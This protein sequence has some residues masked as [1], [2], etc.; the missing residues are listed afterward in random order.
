MYAREG[1]ISKLILEDLYI[2]YGDWQWL[3][4]VILAERQNELEPKP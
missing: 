1:G 3:A 2:G 4:Y